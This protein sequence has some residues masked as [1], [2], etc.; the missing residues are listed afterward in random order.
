ME[1]RNSERKRDNERG[2]SIWHT[3]GRYKKKKEN[4]NAK[5]NEDLKI[6]KERKKRQE[7]EKKQINTNKHISKQINKQTREG[8]KKRNKTP[9]Q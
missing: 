3:H 5:E 8:Y 4:K 1:K 7:K 9:K 2:F 6:Q